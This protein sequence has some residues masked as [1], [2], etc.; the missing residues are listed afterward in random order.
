MD[1]RRWLA[2]HH[3]HRVNVGE[4]R[5]D[6][7]SQHSHVRLLDAL[8]ALENAPPK[9]ARE[10]VHAFSPGLQSVGVVILFEWSTKGRET[11]QTL[12]RGGRGAEG[13]TGE[14]KREDRWSLQARYL[15]LWREA[16]ACLQMFVHR[17]V[18]ERNDGGSKTIKM[19]LA[20]AVEST[21]ASPEGGRG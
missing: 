19:R 15:P 14:G 17:L 8:V 21:A 2:A 10:D 18:S 9:G 1:S 3:V 13:E 4:L 6:V 5:I 7:L 20:K 12:G 16:T 11:W